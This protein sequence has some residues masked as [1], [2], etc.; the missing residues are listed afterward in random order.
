MVSPAWSA[1]RADCPSSVSSRLDEQA[2]PLRLV[3]TVRSRA[4]TLPVGTSHFCTGRRVSESKDC[5]SF[6]PWS[7]QVSV[8]PCIISRD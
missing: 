7:S 3:Q 6:S 1:G 5:A 2:A 4:L 8:Q